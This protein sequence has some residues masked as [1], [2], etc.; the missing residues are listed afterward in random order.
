MRSLLG[1]Y[2][3]YREENTL[4]RLRNHEERLVSLMQPLQQVG[5]Q[6]FVR[7]QK[8]ASRKRYRQYHRRKKKTA[9]GPERKP[10]SI[11]DLHRQ[12]DEQRED[13]Q[14][15]LKKELELRC[16]ENS[17][18]ERDTEKKRRDRE[19]SLLYCCIEKM[20]KLITLRRPKLKAKGYPLAEEDD[21][22][23]AKV[24]QLHRKYMQAPR[25]H[26]ARE[27]RDDID[28]KAESKRP[29][30]DTES[31]EERI[32][33]ADDASAQQLSAIK[34]YSQNPRA[35]Y[36]QADESLSQLIAI[37]SVCSCI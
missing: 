27:E 35:F 14:K 29:P 2:R 36:G 26:S 8:R 1:Q 24:E 19:K 23:L 10:D 5:A 20:S 34:R 17:R 16:A 33:I 25:T 28:R 13:M 18:A 22:F 12:V 31:V 32:D 6:F 4:Q 15:Q 37:R 11:E 30:T 3:R 7:L 21:E 9:R